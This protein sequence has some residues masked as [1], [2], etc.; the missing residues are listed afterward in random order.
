MLWIC[1]SRSL[2]APG[3]KSIVFRQQL[4]GEALQMQ[5]LWHWRQF[6]TNAE[7]FFLRGLHGLG[8]R[9][10]PHNQGNVQNCLGNG[11]SAEE[12]SWPRLR[13]RYNILRRNQL[14]LRLRMIRLGGQWC[15]YQRRSHAS[16][17]ARRGWPGQNWPSGDA[18]GAPCGLTRRSPPRMEDQASMRGSKCELDYSIWTRSWAC[19][20]EH[21]L[22][23]P[24]KT[25]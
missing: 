9:I 13:R 5:F 11:A 22:G 10:R 17:C 25:G 7:S 20:S 2:L 15:R 24:V 1:S 8:G 21:N 6:W 19:I 14:R 12:R 18:P 3:S 4:G 23:H 16:A